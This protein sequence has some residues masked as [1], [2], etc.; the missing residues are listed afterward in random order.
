MRQDKLDVFI[1][2]GRLHI[3]DPPDP[4]MENTRTEE[5]RLQDARNQLG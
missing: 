1:P 5:E 4:T 2:L 3:L